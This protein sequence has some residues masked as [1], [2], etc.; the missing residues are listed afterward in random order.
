MSITRLKKEYLQI[1]KDPNWFYT[2]LP[3]EDN[4]LEWKFILNGPISTIFEGAM[5][6]GKIT[7]PNEYPNRPP[8][9]IF[10]NNFY[11]PN[12][13]L[14]G[15]I[16]ISILHEG[17]DIYG[18]EHSSERWSPSH[19]VNS[20]MLSI[21]SMLPEPNLDSPANVDAAKT[22]RDNYEEYKLRIYKMIS[23]MQS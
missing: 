5:F 8:K 21:V 12:V 2:V 15:K 3:S 23:L 6:N 1:L 13:Y 22:W 9:V 20:I 17:E 11:H 14:D 16:C 10:T 4:F 18:Y 7:F 19:G